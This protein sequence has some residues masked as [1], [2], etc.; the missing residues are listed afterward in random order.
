MGAVF[1]VG[2]LALGPDATRGR[3]I[4]KAR[5]ENI[6]PLGAVECRIPAGGLIQPWVRVVHQSDV[7]HLID[8]PPHRLRII[9]NLGRRNTVQEGIVNGSLL[10]VSKERDYTTV[11]TL[12]SLFP[13]PLEGGIR[14][15]VGVPLPLVGCSIDPA[16]CLCGTLTHRLTCGIRKDDALAH[17]SRPG[18]SVKCWMYTGDIIH[19]AADELV[20]V[21]VCIPL[22][23]PPVEVL[24]H[25]LIPLIEMPHKKGMPAWDRQL[26]W[27]NMP[28]VALVLGTCH[29]H[30]MLYELNFISV[31]TTIFLQESLG[32]RVIRQS[33]SLCTI[34][35]VTDLHI[36]PAGV[37]IMTEIDGKFAGITTNGPTWHWE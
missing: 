34:G 21:V 20:L 12:C 25:C 27:G 10:A 17:L 36:S 14:A 16:P 23:L 19:R 33:P 6:R 15:V 29:N 9:G 24:G 8:P 2:P 30:L 35:H 11:Q 26:I 37:L 7:A 22:G 4:A 5:H 18:G 13:R 3:P 32:V 31:G 1:L 28:A